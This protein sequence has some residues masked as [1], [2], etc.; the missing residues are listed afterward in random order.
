MAV[1][2]RF[3]REI[4]QKPGTAAQ[5]ALPVPDLSGESDENRVQE[6][7]SGRLYP[8]GA[9][10]RTKTGYSSVKTAS[11]TREMLDVACRIMLIQRICQC[12]NSTGL[13]GGGC[14]GGKPPPRIRRVTEPGV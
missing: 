9:G 12:K 10:S 2:T 11:C 1:C 6:E 7:E 5:K 13:R 8:T 4:G 14:G 3:E